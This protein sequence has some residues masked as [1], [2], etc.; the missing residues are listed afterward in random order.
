[1]CPRFARFRPVL[2][3]A[4]ASGLVALEPAAGE[5]SLRRLSFMP[6]QLAANA[7]YRP[8]EPPALINGH[9]DESF[10]HAE[11]WPRL[12]ANLRRLHGSF[13]LCAAEVGWLSTAEDLLPLLRSERI[14][15][16][17]EL[18]GFTQCLGGGELAEAE[19]N[20]APLRS[21]A[22]LF[23]T[24]FR[25]DHPTDRPDPAGHGWFVTRDGQPFVPDEILFDERIPNLLPTFDP[26]V[27]ARTKGT[28]EQR[29]AAALR[30]NGH[31]LAAGPSAALLAD[32]V[33]DYVR[34]LTVARAKFGAQM[35]VVSL[36]WNVNPGW[37]WRD[38]AALDAIQA[39]DP[40]YF[41]VPANFWAIVQRHPQYNSVR[42]LD[43]LLDR[44]AAAGF[45]PRTVFMD[46]DWTYDV[47]YI[48]EVLRRHQADLAA[49]GVQMGVNV[50]EA[51]LGV[52]DELIG[53]GQTLR[54]QTV[55]EDPP[56]LLY[57]RTLMAIAR[58]LQVTGLAGPE[59]QWRV[60][61]WSHRPCEVGRQV[62]EDTPGS[63]A[64]TA[65]AI[66]D[67]L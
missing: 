33:E 38:Q 2:T 31:P 39:A 47:P 53:E 52:Q 1:M 11:R 24:I 10:G 44:L 22:N 43:Q 8:G 3:A 25:L 40:A 67:T 35:P 7:W 56:N 18:P 57:E 4:L 42:Y 30:P 66:A 16:S 13:S 6:N 48:T 49:R 59:L 20:G 36:H 17:V 58:Y 32:L 26:E 51:S 60:G 41:D 50:V 28:W 64:H 9:L 61:S 37:E 14:P 54:R 15:L 65:N 19:L 5:A 12:R 23:A 27:L 63:L 62:S 46:V 55:P 29:K 34:Y 21:G 45:R